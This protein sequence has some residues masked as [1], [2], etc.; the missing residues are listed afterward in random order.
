MVA[1]SKCYSKKLHW[2]FFTTLL[3]SDNRKNIFD[4]N[5]LYC[6]CSLEKFQN[7]YAFL[8]L[9]MWIFQIFCSKLQLSFVKL[10][11]IYLDEDI[12]IKILLEKLYHK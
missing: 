1:S 10:V 3:W 6:S 2:S 4:K 11:V 7:I 12:L 9:I 5:R 8:Y